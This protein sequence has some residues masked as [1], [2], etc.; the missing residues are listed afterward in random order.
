[1]NAL[2]IDLICRAQA[3]SIANRFD[4]SD[5]K[6]L[7]FKDAYKKAW[8]KA[9][10]DQTLVLFTEHDVLGPAVTPDERFYTIQ[11]IAGCNF[12]R[13]ETI[14]ADRLAFVTC[15]R[16]DSLVISFY[17]ITFDAQKIIMPE[18]S[19][20]PHPSAAE[21]LHE[22]LHVIRSQLWI[23]K[24]LR[25]IQYKVRLDRNLR[26][27]NADSYGIVWPKE[28]I[29]SL[30]LREVVD[31][32]CDSDIVTDGLSDVD[33]AERSENDAEGFQDVAQAVPNLIEK[34]L[35]PYFPGCRLLWQCSKVSGLVMATFYQIG[36]FTK[37]SI[38]ICNLQVGA[39]SEGDTRSLTPVYPDV[40]DAYIRFKEVRKGKRVTKDDRL[41]QCLMLEHPLTSNGVSYTIEHGVLLDFTIILTV[42]RGASP[43]HLMEAALRTVLRS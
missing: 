11:S 1:M 38:P 35:Q 18:L 41:M 15:I 19:S 32:D 9:I 21:R 13:I 25:T 36:Q 24:S 26:V 4:S 2:R 20:P 33:E 43:V 30:I 17:L 23:H 31:S 8:Q 40:E 16:D 14:S 39:V 6:A 10:Q 28:A 12:Y 3:R 22:E 42:H 34:R 5:V 27:I 7:V 29:I 37:K